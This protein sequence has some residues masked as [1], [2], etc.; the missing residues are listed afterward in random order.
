MSQ[1]PDGTA[2]GRW[3]RTEWQHLSTFHPSR[4]RWQMPVAAGLATG[5]P[6]LVGVYFGRLDYGLVSSLGGLAFLYLPDTPMHHRMARLMACAFAISACYALGIMSHAVA[7]ATVPLLTVIAVL[8]TMAC[9]YYRVGPPASLFFVMVA[10]IGA[11]SPVPFLELP[12]RVGLVFLGGLLATVIAFGYSL[13]VLR[14]QAP[15]P[16]EPLPQPT[17]DYVVLDSVLI[18]ALVGLSLLLA[19]VLQME[20]PYWVPV[21]CMAVIQGTTLR[22]VWNRNLQRVVGTAVGMLV[23][24]G[25]LSL[26]LGPWTVAPI[27]MLL[28][29]TVEW[30]IVRHY[31]L[32]T[33]FITP[34]TIL[35][36][37]AARLDP[38]ASHAALI[39]SR[40]L[41]TTLGC[42]VGLLGGVVMHQ[43]RLRAAV[44]Q[45]LRALV[46]ARMKGRRRGGR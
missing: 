36:A 21:S 3:L 31:G 11:Y 37:E 7:V 17:F 12:L 2:L 33:V 19:V 26:P 44:G 34:L 30:L 29:F 6:V 1:T 4:R 14:L 22:A 35:L 43:P 18:G 32:A 40:F 13:I 24:W 23:A 46:P 28:S 25:L 10:A 8:V 39:Q 27:L 45:S 41:D 5:L 42:V 16:V 38:Q 9:R 15:T 20:R